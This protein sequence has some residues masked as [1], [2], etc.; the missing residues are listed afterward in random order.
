MSLGR[1]GV[2]LGGGYHQQQA[3]QINAGGRASGDVMLLCMSAT[4]LSDLQANHA[5]RN[6]V[7]TRHQTIAGASRAG[8][9]YLSAGASSAGGPAGDGQ[10]QLEMCE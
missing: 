6:R 7:S 3:G 4:R 1:G 2:E 10:R 5:E 9:T 8:M